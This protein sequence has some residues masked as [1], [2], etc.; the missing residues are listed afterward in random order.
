LPLLLFRFGGFADVFGLDARLFERGFV[1][2][3]IASWASLPSS[4]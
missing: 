4:L 2:A 1:S 3:A